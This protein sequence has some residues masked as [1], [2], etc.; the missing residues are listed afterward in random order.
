LKNSLDE[1]SKIEKLLLRLAGSDEINPE[2]IAGI[3]GFK[4]QEIIALFEILTKAEILN[5]LS[6][7][8]GIDTKIFKNRKAFF[9]S[10]SLRRALL[11]N[12]YGQ[13]IPEQHKSKL[14]GDLVVMYLKRILQNNNISYSSGDSQKNPDIIIETRDKPI[15]LEIGSSKTSII[16]IKNSGIDYRY[17]IL[18]TDNSK[19]LTL[20]ENCIHLPL[21]WFLML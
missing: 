9:M 8:G 16:Q 13:N 3:S 21:N 18:L 14:L 1:S 5:V 11:S 15:I 2:K 10:P 20:N 7:F 4:K 17:G 6:P 12:L 19:E